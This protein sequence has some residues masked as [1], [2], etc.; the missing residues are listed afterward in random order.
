MRNLCFQQILF[1]SKSFNWPVVEF[2]SHV[3]L[4]GEAPRLSIRVF[5][6]ILLSDTAAVSPFVKRPSLNL[7][8]L[9]SVAGGSV[10]KVRSAEE[11]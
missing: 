3:P 2:Y 6:G 7:L 10:G 8:P 4:I 9:I 1:W 11:N 5:F